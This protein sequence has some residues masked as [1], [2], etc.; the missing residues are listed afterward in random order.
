MLEGTCGSAIRR[1]VSFTILLGKA[2]IVYI[3]NYFN[4]THCLIFQSKATAD[5]AELVD[6]AL[7]VQKLR[8]LPNSLN[9]LRRPGH[10]AKAMYFLL[11]KTVW[12]KV[13]LNVLRAP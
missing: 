3:D 11:E 4:P 10:S 7:Q 5:L 9:Q 1:S 2:A 12:E 8:S 13:M 6:R